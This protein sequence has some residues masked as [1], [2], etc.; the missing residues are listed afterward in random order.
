M[1]VYTWAKNH[2]QQTYRFSRDVYVRRRASP[3]STVEI[4]TL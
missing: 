1:F 4:K 3:S 2:V